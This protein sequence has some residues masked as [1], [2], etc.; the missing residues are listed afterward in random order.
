MTIPQYS[1]ARTPGVCVTYSW[2]SLLAVLGFGGKSK[3]KDNRHL[4]AVDSWQ[5]IE[6]LPLGRG[7][8]KGKKPGVGESAL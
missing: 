2:L 5:I 3:S 4:P 6:H 8:L 7:F 1:V